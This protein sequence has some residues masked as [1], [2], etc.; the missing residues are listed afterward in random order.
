MKKI[1][2]KHIDAIKH[3]FSFYKFNFKKTKKELETYKEVLDILSELKEKQD[4][5]DESSRVNL[6]AILKLENW[7]SFSK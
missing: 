3:A 5:E 1:E 4:K 2:Q 6:E 7:R